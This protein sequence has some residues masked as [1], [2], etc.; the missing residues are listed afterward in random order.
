MS[1]E[2]R[3]GG[4]RESWPGVG[5]TL[6]LLPLPQEVQHE[7][8]AARNAQLIVNAEEVIAH[9]VLTDAE[10]DADFPAR[11]SF[12]EQRSD[13]IFALGEQGPSR[14]VNRAEGAGLYKRFEQIM[15]LVTVGPDLTLVNR[16]DALAKC[17]KRLT[18]TK[19]AMSS[20]TKR[21]Y[22]QITS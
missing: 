15:E 22:D 7:L 20:R 8:N 12:G 19:D 4:T 6:G 11:E 3:P 21:V 2:T 13:I 5:E 1:N 14:V 18:A 10:L 17:L 9:R 16:L